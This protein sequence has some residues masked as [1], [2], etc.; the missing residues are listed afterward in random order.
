MSWACPGCS[1]RRSAR[2]TRTSRPVSRRAGRDAAAGAVQGRPGRGE[3]QRTGALPGADRAAVQRQTGTY[4]AETFA[5]TAAG[6][7]LPRSA[8][9]R[10]ASS[11]SKRRWSPISRSITVV[12][13]RAAGACAVARHGLAGR[14]PVRAGLTSAKPAGPMLDPLTLFRQRLAFNLAGYPRGIGARDERNERSRAGWRASPAHV[15][16]SGQCAGSGAAVRQCPRTDRH[17]AGNRR[18]RFADRA[19]PAALPNACRRFRSLVALAGQVGS[20][21][22]IR[23]GN[24]WLLASVRDPAQ[25][26]NRPAGSSPTSTSSAKATRKS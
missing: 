14:A 9:S 5:I 1:F 7:S 15:G 24:G 10:C 4:T 3:G 6:W 25:D 22:K 11:A 17:R 13:L 23:V 21:I 16:N 8:G 12:P 2:S 18:L 20:Q 26:A 19:R